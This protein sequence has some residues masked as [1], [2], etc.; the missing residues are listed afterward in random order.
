MSVVFSIILLVRLNFTY[1]SRTYN[2]QII[3]ILIIYTNYLVNI[4]VLHSLWLRMM[5]ETSNHVPKIQKCGCIFLK[6]I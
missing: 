4:L 2:L 6:F 3:I 5:F 1:L